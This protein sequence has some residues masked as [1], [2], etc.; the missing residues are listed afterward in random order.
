M[1]SEIG[2]TGTSETSGPRASLKGTTGEENMNGDRA[3]VGMK[4]GNFKCGRC[5]LGATRGRR[6]V[7]PY[8]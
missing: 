2:W 4:C 3:F 1:S 8:R 6:A 7:E 5:T